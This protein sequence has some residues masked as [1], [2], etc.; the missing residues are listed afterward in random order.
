MKKKATPFVS[1][2]LS[3]LTVYMLYM[4]VYRQTHTFWVR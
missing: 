2:I 1:E 3:R 4:P